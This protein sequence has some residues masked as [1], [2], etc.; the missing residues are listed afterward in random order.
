MLR[1]LGV[2]VRLGE[3]MALDEIALQARAGELVVVEGGRG[4]GKSTL[5]QIA[6][7]LR[8]LVV[9]PSE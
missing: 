2:S 8:S 7:T 5:L 1:I 6:A 9:S 3:K 4:A